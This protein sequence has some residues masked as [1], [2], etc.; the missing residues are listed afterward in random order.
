VP[1]TTDDIRKLADLARLE[2]T[3]GE[4]ADVSAKLSAIVR[5]VDEL[6]SVATTGVPPMAHP[7]DQKQRL[8][9]DVVTER[10]AHERYQ[11]NAPAVERGLYLVPKVIE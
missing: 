11:R 9:A 10:D 7:L 6:G 4:V 2:I 8:R 3:P 1:L 5:L